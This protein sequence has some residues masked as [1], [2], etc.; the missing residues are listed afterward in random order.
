MKNRNASLVF[1]LVT[2]LID[3]IGFGI[4]IPVM[5]DLITQLGNVS[6][7]QASYYS[8]WMLFAYA[9]MQFIFAPLMGSLSDRFGR[10]P[11]LFISLGGLVIDYM[12]M[13]FA[14]DITWLF[15]GRCIAG[16]MGASFTTASAYIADISEPEKRAQNYGMIGVAFGV[17]FII[18]PS[19]GSVLSQFGLRV[20]FYFAAGLAFV[21]LMYGI[22]VLPES[23]KQ[24]NRR[25]FSWLRAN[26]VGGF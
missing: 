14:P 11:I 25:S 9:V 8:G 13:S 20:P 19:L 5:P 15:V 12:I 6:L 1:I 10:R 17:G 4:I 2:I 3:V 22:F 24:E 21:N 23:L 16:I 18:G 7:S 26:P